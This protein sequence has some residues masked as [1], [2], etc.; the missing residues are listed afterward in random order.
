MTAYKAV[1]GVTISQDTSNPLSSAIN[2]SLKVSVPSG[3]TGWVGFANT[4]YL[5]VPVIETTYQTY[6]W[7]KGDYSGTINLRLVGTVS[8][9]V[10]ASQNITVDSVSSEFTYHE[11]AFTSSTSPDGNNEWELLFEGSKVEDSSLNFG[12]VQ[13]FP[14]TFHARYTRDYS[15]QWKHFEL[16][17]NL[18]IQ[19]L[20]R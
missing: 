14:P 2:S 16:T 11:T 17:E 15:Y 4:G 6:F 20:E 10:Y 8:G 18:Q 1:G 9:I 5:G 12:L 7:I 3:T 13:L 19:W